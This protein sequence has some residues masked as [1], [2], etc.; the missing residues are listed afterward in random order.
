MYLMDAMSSNSMK[1]SN[2]NSGIHEAEVTKCLDTMCLDP[3][4]NQG[5]C[6]V[7]IALE[8]NGARPSHLGKGFSE[9]GTMYTLNTIEQHS[10]CY[11][12][13]QQGGKSNCGY[14]ENVMPTL[15]SDSH[16]TP[17]AVCFR[18]SC[19]PY[20][21]DGLGEKWVEDE[22]TNTLNCFEFANDTR[23]PEIV[24]QKQHTYSVDCRNGCLNEEL[25]ITLQA[26]N[27]GG[28]SVNCT[29][30]ILLENHE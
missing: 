29:P 15:C 19:K 21:K 23:T 4:C 14:A 1:S 26:K 9:D 25:S 3:G 18:K 10:V 28:F 20:G 22:V 7:C 16:G 12:I 2:P 24:V 8:G 11:G 6:M 27:Q 5:G 17:H 13:D 30:P